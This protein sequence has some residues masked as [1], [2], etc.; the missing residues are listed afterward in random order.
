[1]MTPREQAVWG[2][3]YALHSNPGLEAATHADQVVGTLSEV[4]CPETEAPEHRAARLI[5]GLSFDEF[6]G[7]YLVEQRVASRG[8]RRSALTEADIQKAFE[9][10]VMCSCD[11]Y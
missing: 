8:G 9:I 3:V 10:Y 1:M 6:R 7:W 4:E 5:T 11:F 2:A